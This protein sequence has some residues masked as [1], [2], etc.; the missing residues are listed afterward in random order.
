LAGERKL[1]GTKLIAENVGE[2]GLRLKVPSVG[3]EA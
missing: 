2:A 1:A 3:R